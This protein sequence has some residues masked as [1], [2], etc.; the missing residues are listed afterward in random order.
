M[1]FKDVKAMMEAIEK[2]C[3]GEATVLDISQA[4]IESH[5]SMLDLFIKT[6]IA[7]TLG[8]PCPGI[9]PWHVI[10]LLMVLYA[11]RCDKVLRGTIIAIKAD[12]G[13]FPK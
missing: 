9:E 1:N 3:K 6:G 11:H 4:I 7:D 5:E 8:N 12:K 13:N 2:F 10:G